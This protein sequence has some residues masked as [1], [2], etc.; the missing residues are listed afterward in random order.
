[1]YDMRWLSLYYRV[2][3]TRSAYGAIILAI[4]EEFTEIIPNSAQVKKDEEWSTNSPWPNL[5]F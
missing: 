3:N 1:M 2:K 4:T 5:Q